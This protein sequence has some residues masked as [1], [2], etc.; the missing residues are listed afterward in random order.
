MKTDLKRESLLTRF[1]DP[2]P[3]WGVAKLIDFSAFHLS[4]LKVMTDT[5]W[6]PTLSMAL[7]IRLSVVTVAVWYAVN[8]NRV[9]EYWCCPA[10]WPHF[11]ALFLLSLLSP[12]LSSSLLFLLPTCIFF[13]YPIC[14]SQEFCITSSSPRLTSKCYETEL[15]SDI[16]FPLA[17]S[18][19]HH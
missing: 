6:P 17:L 1:K 5:G 14:T 16:P 10:L 3:L 19:L 8:Y 15:R 13:L 9:A 2:P 11:S 4:W 12:S 18:Q 7:S